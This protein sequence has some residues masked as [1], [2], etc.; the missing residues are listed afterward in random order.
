MQE[1]CSGRKPPDEQEKKKT[2]SSKLCLAEGPQVERQQ[3]AG[4]SLASLD[5]ADVIVLATA[6]RTTA[7]PVA[8]WFVVGRCRNLQ[9]RC[10]DS[11]VRGKKNRSWKGTVIVGSDVIGMAERVYARSMRVTYLVILSFIQS[12]HK[13]MAPSTRNLTILPSPL[14]LLVLP[15]FL[16][17]PDGRGR[18]GSRGGGGGGGGVGGG[19]EDVVQAASRTLFPVAR[20]HD[21]LDGNLG[22]LRL[23]SWLD[24]VTT[25]ADGNLEF[26]KLRVCQQQPFFFLP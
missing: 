5:I 22:R 26:A 4:I 13:L 12:M 9:V 21:G 7:A 20:E 14:L 24:E 15:S 1:S 11:G 8:C 3:A 23:D 2:S 18:H 10:P 19:T 25:T 17:I 16:L 6:R